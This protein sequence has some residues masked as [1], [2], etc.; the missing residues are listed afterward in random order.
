VLHLGAGTNSPELIALAVFLFTHALII[1]RRIHRAV[2]AML[3]ASVLVFWSRQPPEEIFE[4]IERPALFF[5]GGLFV[6]AGT[7]ANLAGFVV[8]NVHSTGDAVLIIAWFSAP[9]SA[10]VDNIPLTATLIPLIQNM[11]ASMDMYPLWWALSLG[12]CLGGNGS[13]IGASANVVVLRI[14]ARNDIGISFI[15]FLKVG[16]LVLV[17]TVG[18]GTGILWLGY[19]LP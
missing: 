16:K 7:I 18:I 4:K 17:L 9:A 12:A 10:V 19:V 1:D 6:V 14:A 8:S 13:A 5:F 3:G 11:G 15:E 2:A